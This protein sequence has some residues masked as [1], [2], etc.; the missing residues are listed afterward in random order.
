VRAAILLVLVG[1]LSLCGCAVLVL[2]S[3]AP[4]APPN[5]AELSASYHQTELNESGSGDVLATIQGSEDELVSQSKSVVASLGQKNKGSQIWFNMVAFDENKVKAQRKYFFLI[6]EK[7]QG[8]LMRPRRSLVFDS[9]TVLE[10]GV[11]DKPYTDENSRRIAILRQVLESVRKDIDEVGSANKML[12]ISG[13]IINQTLETVLRKLDESPVLASRL[14]EPSGVY[15]DHIT[16][17]KGSIKMDVAEDIAKAQVRLGTLS[18]E[19]ENP[20]ALEQ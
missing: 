18:Y 6:N 8:L 10:T 9:E 4:V 17:G 5:Y 13:M 1:C 14:G 16:L 12:A 2:G 7:P 3:L 15:F 11:L 19:F 20:F